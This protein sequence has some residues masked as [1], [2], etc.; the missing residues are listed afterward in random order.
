MARADLH[1]ALAVDREILEAAAVDPALLDPVVRVPSG[2]PGEARPFVVV[3]DYQGP[4]GYYTERF[5]IV[6]AKGRPVHHSGVRRLRLRG[7]MFEDRFTDEVRGLQFTDPDEHA[8]RFF[9][10][11]QAVGQVPLFLESGMGG[12][13]RLAAEETFKKAIG[14]G[15]I[16]WIT[17]PH[18]PQAGRG[19]AKAR[20]RPHTQPVWFI[21]QGTTIFVLTGPG[22]Q[23]VQG[24]TQ[25][26]EVEITARSKDHRSR[27]ARVQ[28]S[29]RVL[30]K[31]DPEW[32]KLAQSAT[33]KRLNLPDKTFED[34][35]RRW[36]ETC[37]IVQLTPKFSAQAA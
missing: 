32:V 4:V 21:A 1:Y 37:E 16:I 25:A 7:E 23:D 34:A 10:D 31:D 15:E 8:L 3:R 22:E 33:P 17:V 27:V 5:E 19:T 11:D 26:T 18:V 6:D 14:K 20:L 13:P 12:D 24:L 29:V 9:I 2:L 36:R 30:P 28:A 35:V